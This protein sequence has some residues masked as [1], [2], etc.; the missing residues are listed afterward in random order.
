M[1]KYA[2]MDG[3]KRGPHLDPTREKQRKDEMV[4]HVIC[5]RYYDCD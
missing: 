4:L 5:D 1:F 2:C 3:T